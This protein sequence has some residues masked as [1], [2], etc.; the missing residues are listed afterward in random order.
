[1][2][3]LAKMKSAAETVVAFAKML[4]GLDRVGLYRPEAHYMRGP[5]PKWR[6][7]HGEPKRSVVRTSRHARMR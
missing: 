6:A 7:A 1:M 4:L 5:G 3:R 2:D